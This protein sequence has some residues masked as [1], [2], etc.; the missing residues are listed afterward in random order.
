VTKQGGSTLSRDICEVGCS[1]L[2][3]SLVVVLEEAH[4]LAARRE[5]ELAVSSQKQPGFLLHLARVWSAAPQLV[6][7]G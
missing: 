6:S 3:V 5:T 2:Q 1:L 7:H 4:S